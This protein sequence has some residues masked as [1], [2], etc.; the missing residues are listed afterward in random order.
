MN[1]GSSGWHSLGH[2]HGFALQAENPFGESRSGRASGELGRLDLMKTS[3]LAG[4]GKRRVVNHDGNIE[5]L[6]VGDAFG[7]RGRPV[8]FQMIVTFPGGFGR[9]GDNGEKQTAPP[10]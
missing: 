10:F 2:A 5:L 3:R 7:S 8:S 4:C 9:A 1:Q 6:V